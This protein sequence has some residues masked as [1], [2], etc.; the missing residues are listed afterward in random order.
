MTR[1]AGEGLRDRL[2]A[3][4]DTT[5]IAG[6]IGPLFTLAI[7][8]FLVLTVLNQSSGDEQEPAAAVQ[9]S[10]AA[11]EPML[12]TSADEEPESVTSRDPFFIV[13]SNIVDPDGNLFVSVGVNGAIKVTDYPYVFEGGNGGLNGRVESIQAWG[14]NTVRATLV[15]ANEDGEPSINEVADGIDETVQELTAAGIVVI[16]AC[17]DATGSDL[18]LDSELDLAVRQFWDR[19]VPRYQSNPYVW[20][21]FYNEPHG[22]FDPE[23]WVKLHRFYYDR[24]RTRGVENIMVFD[25]PNFGQGVDLVADNEFAD[26]LG[27]ACNTLF[28]WHGWGALSGR[29]ATKE[30]Y[31]NLAGI[32]LE[33]G[34]AVA[35]TEAGVPQPLNAGTAGEPEWNESGYYAALEVAETWPIGLLWWH[36]TGDTSNELFYP[37]KADKSGFWTSNNS[38]ALTRAGASFWEHSH[39]ERAV[40]QFS[41]DL[42]DSA[43]PSSFNVVAARAAAQAGNG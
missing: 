42:T 31:N 14:W 10:S 33:R 35:I 32:L 23:S 38:G 30:E 5:S 13:D 36:G 17:H 8:A 19:V 29:Q 21:N 4:W 1:S 25:L 26:E 43:C 37:L 40:E 24:Y 34:L 12:Q 6:I 2:N 20:F 18:Q 15:C 41:G 27:R 28:G 16:L 39:Q 7:V 9:G 11:S 3:I 22:R